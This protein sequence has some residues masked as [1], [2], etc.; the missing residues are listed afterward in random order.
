VATRVRQLLEIGHEVD[1]VEL[2]IFGGTLT[3]YPRDYME[4]FVTECLNA[5][6]GSNAGTIDEAQRMAERAPIR[7][8]DIV[9]ETRPDYCRE[10]HVD[11]MLKLG[12]TRVELGVQTVFDDIYQIVKREHTVEDVVDATRVARD[13]GFAVVYHLMPNLPGSSY[14]RDLELFRRIF[15]DP[16]FK[17]DAIKIYPTLV[18][19]ETKLYE[20]W[21]RGKYR[22]YPFEKLLDLIQEIKRMTPPWVRIQRIQRDIPLNLVAHGVER[23]DIRAMIQER[24][25]KKGQ[26][27]R[28]VRCREVGHASRVWGVK[29]DRTR[30]CL[31]RR[32]YEASEGVEI[33][34][35]FED[36][37]ADVLVGLLRLRIPSE[38]AW[39]PEVKRAALVRELHVYGP[40][41]RVGERSECAW[42]HRGYGRQLI[43]E[44]ERIAR[45]EYDMQKVGILSGIGVR[46]YYRKLGYRRDGPYM[47]KELVD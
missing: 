19:P 47:V 37:V 11:F 40:L 24:M 27:C 30:V 43:V 42:Q 36:P 14:E 6:S 20:L 38:Q 21:K 44:A 4:W 35:S 12:A 25:R 39:R 31:V 33:F 3:A 16:R 10:S 5:L 26:R 13:A 17:P 23:G 8:S 1:K 29:P 18:M 2:I 46:E 45:E 7:I 41:V 9:L 22:P 15:W 34:L 32:D 28:C